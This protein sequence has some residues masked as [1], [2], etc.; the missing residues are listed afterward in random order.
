VALRHTCIHTHRWLRRQ[1]DRC[2]TCIRLC[3]PPTLE[4][5]EEEL[6][7]GDT[8]D[9]GEGINSGKGGEGKE[10]RMKKYLVGGVMTDPD[11]AEKNGSGG[12]GSGTEPDT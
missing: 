9:A 10:A 12:S 3:Q 4:S 5:P 8:D 1:R 7:E 11:S 2:T 6:A